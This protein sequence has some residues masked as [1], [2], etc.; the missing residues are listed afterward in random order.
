V[1]I[2]DFNILPVIMFGCKTQTLTL[3]KE[4]KLR[5]FYNRVL[6]EIFRLKRDQLTE[7]LR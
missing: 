3:R 5:M 2:L 7:Q 4:L 1:C 6:R